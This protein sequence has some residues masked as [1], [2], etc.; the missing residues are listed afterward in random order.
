MRCHHLDFI[1]E[2]GLRPLLTRPP[3]AR[4]TGLGRECLT[5]QLRTHVRPS[6]ASSTPQRVTRGTLRAPPLGWR[7]AVLLG[8]LF[9]PFGREENAMRSPHLYQIAC[10]RVGP[11]A[12]PTA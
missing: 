2:I 6:L 5:G 12:R 8:L 3:P 1:A 10:D 11:F 4:S 7:A 9:K